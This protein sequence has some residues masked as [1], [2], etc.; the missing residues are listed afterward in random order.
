[1]DLGM[2]SRESKD[3]DIAMTLQ[4]EWFGGCRFGS[5]T[6]AIDLATMRWCGLISTNLLVENWKSVVEVAVEENEEKRQNGSGTTVKAM[7]QMNIYLFFEGN[8]RQLCG[9]DGDHSGTVVLVWIRLGKGKE[10]IRRRR[11]F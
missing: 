5:P 3:E 11:R 2:A 6:M 1:M 9:V 10:R 7:Q 8:W 4:L